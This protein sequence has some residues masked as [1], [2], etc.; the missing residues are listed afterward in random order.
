ML[1]SRV[2]IVLCVY[3]IDAMISELF[4]YIYSTVFKKQHTVR[5]VQRRF[6]LCIHT[7]NNKWKCTFMYVQSTGTVVQ[8]Q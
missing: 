8:E 6:T 2:I 7:C 4:I 3:H 5:V 1:Q